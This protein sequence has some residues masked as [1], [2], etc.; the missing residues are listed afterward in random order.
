MKHKHYGIAGLAIFGLTLM[1]ILFYGVYLANNMAG[2]IHISPPPK[3]P[4][5]KVPDKSTLAY[6]GFLNSHLTDIAT[7]KKNKSSV[8]LKLFGFDPT[9]PRRDDTADVR[10]ETTAPES[11]LE[12]QKPASFPYRLTLCFSAKKN[13]FCVIDGDLY[14]KNGI[15]PD[16]GNILKIENDRVLVL[17]HHTKKWIYPLQQQTLSKKKNEEAI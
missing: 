3:V 7:L 15:L 2:S 1:G 5:L 12:R 4:D 10:D 13:S 6:I 17:K 11:K 16:G 8:D 14:K 9:V